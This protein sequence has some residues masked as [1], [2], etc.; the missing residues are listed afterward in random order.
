MNEH[1]N[2]RMN[3]RAFA[4][5]LAAG[6][7]LGSLGPVALATDRLALD[8]SP[9]SACWPNA[10]TCARDR[11]LEFS[12]EG[13]VNGRFKLV[14]LDDRSKSHRGEQ[15]VVRFHGPKDAPEGIYRLR[16]KNRDLVL[17]LQDVGDGSGEFDAVIHHLA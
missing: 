8:E 16:A 14:G 11:G 4:A 3:R 13:P 6:A 15:F 7:A 1:N 17:F 9:I 10:A 2:G 5:R 12:G